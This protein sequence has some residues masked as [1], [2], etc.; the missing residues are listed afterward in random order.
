MQSTSS[1]D[2]KFLDLLRQYDALVR[3][4]CLMYS[5]CSDDFNDLHQE[6][7][8]HLWQGLD[9]FRGDSK[10]STWIYRT[11]INSCISWLRLNRRHRN[12]SDIEDAFNMV[13]S[14]D[15]EQ[16]EQLRILYDI[17]SRLDSIE[18]ALIMM[19]LD[20]YSYDEIAEVVGIT[21][22][23][24][25]TRLHRIRNKMKEMAMGSDDKNA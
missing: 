25:A 4:V 1:K 18:K 23:N 13:V 14:D 17:I 15:G 19:W 10:I 6:T 22:Q 9:S 5:Q 11:T 24:V 2:A 8:I 12:H 20:S 3:R 7:M 21:R 16:R